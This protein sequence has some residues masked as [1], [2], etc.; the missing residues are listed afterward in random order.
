MQWVW[1]SPEPAFND[2][3]PTHCWQGHQPGVLTIS[4]VSPN[5]DAEWRSL[6][7]LTLHRGAIPYHIRIDC[8][9]FPVRCKSRWIFNFPGKRY[10]SWGPQ[11]KLLT[12]LVSTH[13]LSIGH[14]SDL[15]FM[16]SELQSALELLQLNNYV[17]S[18]ATIPLSLMNFTNKCSC[19]SHCCRIWLLWVTRLVHAICVGL[20]WLF[21]PYYHSPHLLKRGILFSLRMLGLVVSWQHFKVDYVWVRRK[22]SP[23]KYQISYSRVIGQILDLGLHNVCTGLY[24][25]LGHFIPCIP[26]WQ[27]C[28]FAMLVFPGSC[29]STFEKDNRL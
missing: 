16:S 10:N 2:S 7:C 20:K 14:R 1:S 4:A 23:S 8:T 18:K 27:F 21:Q 17:S 15:H 22:P 6:H 26:I 19:G 29:R 11:L 5:D 13:N 3:Y 12:G 9:P 24:S 28:R 25:G